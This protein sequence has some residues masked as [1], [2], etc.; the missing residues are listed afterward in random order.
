MTEARQKD[1][2]RV[3]LGLMGALTTHARGHTNTGPARLA[4]LAKFDREVDPNN[5]LDPGERERRAKYALRLHM[6]R[7]NAKRWPKKVAAR[8]VETRAAQTMEGHRHD[9]ASSD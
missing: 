9:R 5:T 4:L 7:L 3:R 1:P 6:L 2:E 8:G